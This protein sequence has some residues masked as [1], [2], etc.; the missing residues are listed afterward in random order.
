M[1]RDQFT[2]AVQDLSSDSPTID[3]VYDGPEDELDNRLREEGEPLTATDLDAAFRL[4]ASSE[5]GEST[6][7]EG[8]F[9]LTNRLTGAYLL[10]VNIDADRMR[11]L[12]AAAREVD[13]DARYRI[14]IRID[15]D[16]SVIYEMSALFVYNSEGKLLRQR[17]LIPSGVEL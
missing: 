9:S 14:R 1:R 6:A 15:R 3:I 10:E 11:E 2:A 8:V 5:A 16:E 12:V 4:L 7:S 17:S 13:D